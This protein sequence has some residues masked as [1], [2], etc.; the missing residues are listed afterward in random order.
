MN[1][2]PANNSSTA[3]ITIKKGTYSGRVVVPAN[4]R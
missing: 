1:L 2:V 4:K 3:T